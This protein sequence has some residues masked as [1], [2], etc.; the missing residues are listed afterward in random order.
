[1]LPCAR[2]LCPE[3]G[4][5]WRVFRR[6][7]CRRAMHDEGGRFPCRPDRFKLSRCYAAAEALAALIELEV[8]LNVV[9]NWLPRPFMAVI[10]ATAMRA[11]IRPYSMAVAPSSLRNSLWKF[12]TTFM[13]SLL[14]GITAHLYPSFG[15]VLGS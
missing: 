15:A 2:A 3:V 9:C 4:M 13:V 8:V 12:R 7:V 11:A 6:R 10:A 1:M 5:A 14:L